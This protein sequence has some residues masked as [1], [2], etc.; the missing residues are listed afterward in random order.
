MFNRFRLTFRLVLVWSICP[1]LAWAQGLVMPGAGPANR[2]MAGASTAAPLDAAGAGYWNPAAISG[3]PG[4]EVYF[5]AELIYA[6]T[7]VDVEPLPPA[8]RLFSQT[9][10][11][12]APTIAMV[13]HQEDSPITTGL[14]V[15]AL[16]G[17]AVNFPSRQAGPPLSPV[18]NQ[19]ASASCL[20]IA[21]MISVQ[22]T[23]R[24]A[25]GAGP[26]IDIMMLSL[27]PAFFAPNGDGSFP[28]ATHGRPF[29]GGGFQ[30]G[31]YYE[32]NPCWS[33]GLSY[34]STQWFE[35]FRWNALDENDVPRDI[36]LDLTLP[37]IVSWGAAYH[38]FQRTTLA[39]DIRYLEY[40]NAKT[41]GQP[42]IEGGTGWE[43]IF[44]VALGIE[45]QLGQRC[46]LRAG[47]LFN[48]NPIPAPL[49]LFNTEL[50]AINQHQISLGFSMQ[51]TSAISMDFA[52]IHGLDNS[53]RGPIPASEIPGG[54]SIV[55][56]QSLDSWALGMGVNF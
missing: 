41:F 55:L 47:Y 44:A 25:V 15:Y 49:T 5:G 28:S 7:R 43:S 31:L 4:N 22:L 32:L 12:A 54:Q 27:D 10:V 20:Q 3:L 17:G 45:R 52:W 34:K 8:G 19:Y 42:V 21:P 50:P 6:D 33:F 9:G 39:L 56:E 37:W 40:S 1:S 16:V 29:W 13:Y 53:I 18:T 24:L 46:K 51:M 23:D 36:S 2:A 26:T 30:A 35:T 38:G 11:A 14:G 48:E